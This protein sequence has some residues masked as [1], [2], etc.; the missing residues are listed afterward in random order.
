MRKEKAL[1]TLG[2]KSDCSQESIYE[3][4][5][6]VYFQTALPKASQRTSSTLV[7]HD[8]LKEYNKAF[9]ALCLPELDENT[10]DHQLLLDLGIDVNEVKQHITANFDVFPEFEKLIEKCNAHAA[11]G[12]YGMAIRLLEIGISR[13]YELNRYK[14]FTGQRRLI[15]TLGKLLLDV[16]LKDQGIGLLTIG[17]VNYYI[18]KSF[19]EIRDYQSAIKY[20]G[21]ELKDRKAKVTSQDIVLS[22]VKCYFLLGEYSNCLHVVERVLPNFESSKSKDWCLPDKMSKILLFS[23]SKAEQLKKGVLTKFKLKLKYPVSYR[24]ISKNMPSF[25]QGLNFLDEIK[26]PEAFDE[27][28]ASIEPSY[29]MAESP[30]MNYNEEALNEAY[31]EIFSEPLNSSQLYNKR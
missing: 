11:Q 24:C 30:N 23:I 8:K 14:A 5:R 22:I 15:R 3:A 10:I 18:G 20:Y 12:H 31:Y 7:N 6:A 29:R 4:Y 2:L 16:G 21:R 1:A 25:H 28:V 19:F 9:A 26:D 17:S 13:S 27:F